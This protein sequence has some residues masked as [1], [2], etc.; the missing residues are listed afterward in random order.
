MTTAA[1]IVGLAVGLGAVL[2]ALTLTQG[3]V[4]LT[5]QS[6]RREQRRREATW[7]LERIVRATLRA[8][9]GV[10]PDRDP[11]CPDEP[12]EL[13][14]SGALAVRADFDR[15]DL[16][17]ASSPEAAL[18]G[19]FRS[20]ATGNDE[21]LVFTRRPDSGPS[22]PA[23]QF[24]ADLDSTDRVTLADGTVVA[25]RDGRTESIDIGPNLVA[26]DRR[27]GSIYRTHFAHDAT[28]FGTGRFR[29]AE[30]LC[31]NASEL[32][33]RAWDVAG[34]ALPDCGGAD[35]AASRSCRAAVAR[36]AIDLVLTL[37]DGSSERFRRTVYR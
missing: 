32:S 19:R 9:L 24:D 18:V 4:R 8:G 5:T 14:T 29:N 12:I 7:T 34:V 11:G 23:L 3:F 37:P 21:L 25:R 36:L 10:C 17:L 15:D 6:A 16:L 28:L 35:D 2:S 26:A 33:F 22:G 20:V 31:D 1:T 30:P 27:S 13:L